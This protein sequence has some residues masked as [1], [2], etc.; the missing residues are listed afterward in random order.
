VER[1]HLIRVSLGEGNDQELEDVCYAPMIINGDSVQV[2]ALLLENEGPTVT[3]AGVVD[4]MDNLF[5]KHFSA[6][7]LELDQDTPE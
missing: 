1:Q 7:G 3:P 6:P 4:P 2:H 5:F